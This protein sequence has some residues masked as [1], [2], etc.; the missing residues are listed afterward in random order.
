MSDFASLT[1]NENHT[2]FR[3]ATTRVGDD[4]GDGDDI[5]MYIARFKG[6]RLQEVRTLV[7]L[8]LVAC[9]HARDSSPLGQ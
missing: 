7:K 6:K 3:H 8:C 2:G 1:I 5:V 9:I 4:D